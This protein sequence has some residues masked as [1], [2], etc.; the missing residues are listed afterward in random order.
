MQSGNQVLQGY[1]KQ[2]RFVILRN[3]VL[4]SEDGFLLSEY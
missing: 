2:Q 4:S 1:T 3:M